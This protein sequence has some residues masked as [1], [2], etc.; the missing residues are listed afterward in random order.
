MTVPTSR[1]RWLL[2]PLLATGLL[3]LAYSPARTDTPTTPAKA[4]TSASP[5]DRQITDIEKQIADLTKKLEELKAPPPPPEGTIPNAWANALQWRCIGPANM[6]G[7]ITA[8]AVYE[9]DPTTFWIATAS[10]GLLKTTNNGISFKHQFDKQA[11]VS[12]GDVAVAPTNKDIVWVGTGENNP[13]NS[14]SYGD[15]VY[16]SVDGGETWK[17]MGLN[18]SFQIGKILIHPKDPNIVYVGALGRLYGPNSERGVFKTTDGGQSWTKVLD[19]GS[20]TGIIDMRM[21]PDDTETLIVAAWERKRDEFDGFFGDPPVPDMYGP[22]VTHAPGSALYRTADGGKTWTKLTKGLP[23]VK[24]G[25]I[26]LDWSRKNTNVVFA[27]IDSEKVGTGAPPSAVYLGVQ[28]EDAANGAKLTNVVKDGPADRAGLKVGDIITTY[29]KQPVKTYD[30]LVEAVRQ[31]KPGDKVTVT[32]A[33]EKETKDLTITLGARPEQPEGRQIITA[34]FAGEDV[35]GG[36]Q[37]ERLLENGPAAKAGLKVKDVVTAIDDQPIESSRGLFRMFSDRQAGDKIQLSVTRGQE[38]LTL[39]VALESRSQDALMALMAPGRSGGAA[40]P[41]S[42]GLGGQRENVQDQQ[43]KD[44]FQTGGVY[45]SED[46]GLTWKRINSLNPRPMYFSQIRVDPSNDE[47]IWVLGVS[48]YYSFDGG[49]KFTQGRDRGVHSDHHALWIDPRDSRHMIIGGDG[50]FYQT[51]DQGQQWDH[52]NHLALG[53]FYHVAIDMRRQYHVYGGLQDNGS[54]GGPSMSIRGGIVN[55]DWKYINGGDGFVCRVDPTDADIVYCESQG[56]AMTRRNM[57][58]G[59]RASI[60]PGGAGGGGAARNRFNWNTPFILSN[61]NPAI[62]YCASQYVYRSLKR[63]DDL[64][65]ISPEIALTPKGS[66]TA[67]AESPR[68]ADVLWAGTDDGGL[69][70]TRDGGQKWTNV[71]DNVKKAGLP[72]PRWVATIE[73]SKYVEG[74]AYVTFD[75]HRSDDDNPYIFVTEDFGQTWK[76]ISSNLPWGSTRCCR[77]D[78]VNQNVLYVGTEFAAYASIN[79]GASWTKINSVTPA[80]SA[81]PTSLPTVAIH[82]FAQHPITGELVAATHGRSIWICDVSGLRQLTAQTIKE[83]AKLYAPTTAIRYRI[84]ANRG[85]FSGAERKFVGTNPYNGATI[86][87][88]LGDKAQKVE[89]KVLDY[90]GQVVRQ[91]PVSTEAGLHRVHWELTRAPSIRPGGGPAGGPG[92]G[93]RR[94]PGGGG[95]ARGPMGGGAAQTP[96]AGQ[97]GAAGGGQRFGGFG[98]IGA[99]VPPGMYRVVLMVDGQEFTQPLRVEA[100][101]NLPAGAAIADEEDVEEEDVEEEER[102]EERK[103]TPIID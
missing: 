48:L 7:R 68:N 42:S 87:Y 41:Y 16:K 21:K 90:A 51:Y 46:A 62:F 50:G 38:K 36:I 31:H 33:R 92:A 103:P 89:L 96:P 82:E 61:H 24:L 102:K 80:G 20:Q 6:G 71:L 77:E 17:N 63:G 4:E 60:R 10:G 49:K 43:G 95:A 94:G 3:T 8:I 64:K 35:T 52:L 37:V 9:A 74:R 1:L 19:L 76:N 85:M 66:G 93:G 45:K 14:V 99:A 27:I 88:S 53:Q 44:G 98:Q 25:R 30:G 70:I 2:L 34:G 12:I 39:T 83:R 65:R 57:R 97:P 29:E 79:R 23:T 73:A 32:V 15:G 67:L 58:T 81:V 91:L 56:G 13:R 59:E 78:I 55:D 86:Y 26:G 84:E 11:T 47:T 40:R 5:R 100:D 75:A 28:G 54:W 18:K 22:I 101:P 69:W 72:G